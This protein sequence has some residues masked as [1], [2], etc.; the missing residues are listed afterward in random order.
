M[1]DLSTAQQA[2]LDNADYFAEQSVAKCK[3]FLTACNQLLVLLPASAGDGGHNA[4]FS[5]ESIAVQLRDAKNWLSTRL[6]EAARSRTRYTSFED[7]R[8]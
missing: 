3:A 8:D 2:F 1:T 7:F 6:D 5:I 4:A